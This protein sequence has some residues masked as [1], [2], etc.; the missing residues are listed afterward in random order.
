V[1]EGSVVVSISSRLDIQTFFLH[2]PVYTT[3]NSCPYGKT[4]NKER[5]EKGHTFNKT[6]TPTG[7]KRTPG[8]RKSGHILTIITLSRTEAHRDV[9]CILQ[10]LGQTSHSTRSLEKVLSQSKDIIIT[11]YRLVNEFLYQSM[12]KRSAVDKY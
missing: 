4:D 8:K 2:L 3:E 10:L 11:I 12:A 7:R 6:H 1:D 5:E 9:G